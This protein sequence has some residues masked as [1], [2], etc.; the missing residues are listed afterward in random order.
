M[1]KHFKFPLQK[2]LLNKPTVNNLFYKR[3]DNKYL[4]FYQLH[5]LFLQRLKSANLMQ[6][7]QTQHVNNGAWLCSSETVF[8]KISIGPQLD[9]EMI[10]VF[11]PLIQICFIQIFNY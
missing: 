7:N 3:S 6:N 8:T 5:V 4:G 10:A 1:R 9:S 2:I 11:Q